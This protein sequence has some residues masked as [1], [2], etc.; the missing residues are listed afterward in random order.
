MHFYSIVEIILFNTPIMRAKWLDQD[1]LLVLLFHSVGG[2]NSLYV[3]LNYHKKLLEYIHSNED[4]IYV[5][6]LL[7]VAEHIQNY[8]TQN[9]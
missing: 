7:E 3:Q 4:Y 8:Q 5:A 9:K 1:T 6:R 2:G